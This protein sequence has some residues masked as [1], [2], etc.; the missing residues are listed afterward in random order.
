M[1]WRSRA[2]RTR[3]S[4]GEGG[5]P[6]RVFPALS[7]EPLGGDIIAGEGLPSPSGHLRTRPPAGHLIPANSGQASDP[8]TPPAPKSSPFSECRLQWGKRPGWQRDHG[9]DPPLPP[10]PKRPRQLNA[11][12]P[13]GGPRGPGLATDSRLH[14]APLWTLVLA[15]M[16]RGCQEISLFPFLPP[17]THGSSLVL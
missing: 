5:L 3:T 14:L 12:Q 15:Q 13:R 2:G 1:L 10:F 4:P 16:T 8:D 11:P 7:D 6:S 9:R 17:V